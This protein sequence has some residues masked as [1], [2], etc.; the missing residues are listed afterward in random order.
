MADDDPNGS[1]LP[2]E[3]QKQKLKLFGCMNETKR[4]RRTSHRMKIWK[5]G[6]ARIFD[7]HVIIETLFANNKRLQEG[8]Q[9][10][11]MAKSK[12]LIQLSV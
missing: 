3:N 11:R 7:D 5:R 6:L 12:V 4:L 1:R 9:R 8:E 2:E 10:S